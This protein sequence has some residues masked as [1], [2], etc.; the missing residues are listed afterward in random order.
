LEKL[1][2]E[3]RTSVCVWCLERRLGTDGRAR[4]RRK[5]SR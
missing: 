5:P 3:T 1:H 2:L 4:P